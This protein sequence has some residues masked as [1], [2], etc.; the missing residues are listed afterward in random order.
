MQITLPNGFAQ[1]AQP[2]EWVIYRGSRTIDRMADST[3]RQ[4]YEPIV[5][6]LTLEDST[7][8]ALDDVLGPGS[9]RSAQAL[10]EAVKRV[11]AIHIGGVSVQFSPGQLEEIA[12]RAAKNGRTTQEEIERVVEHLAGDVF[13]QA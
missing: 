3:F 5:S 12:T 9:T 8:G 2:G 4:F 13:W 11:V 6:G 1:I 10:L 7:K